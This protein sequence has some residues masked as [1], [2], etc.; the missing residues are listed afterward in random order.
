M[1]ESIGNYR[2]ER[3]LGEGAASI[4]Y[5]AVRETDGLAVALK[6]FRRRVT[7][8]AQSR[9]RIT[10]EARAASSM[11]H[12][13]LLPVV[14]EGEADG[15]VFLALEYAPGGTLETL[16][17]A[18]RLGVG[19]TVDVTRDVCDGLSALHAAGIIHRDVKPSN[20]VFRKNGSAAL[21]DFGL[22]K[23][24]GYTALTQVGRVLGTLG[25]LAPELINGSPASVASDVYSLS[26]VVYACLAGRPP[27][28]T[29]RAYELA[30]AHL[31]QIPADIRD[32]N[33]DVPADMA[34]VLAQGLAKDPAQRPPTAVAYAILLT[35]GAAAPRGESATMPV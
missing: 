4:V 17:A 8:D 2:L 18:R 34:S 22:I 20:I 16:I 5:L 14:E 21:T 29:A 10:H 7:A 32:F 6:V 35:A 13:H 23:G 33:P 27:F 15:E 12:A 30:Y 24:E 9:R 31:N 11:N 25:Y 3:I 1:Q 28:E 26:C 19:E